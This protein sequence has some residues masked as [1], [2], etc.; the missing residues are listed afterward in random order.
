MII[1]LIIDRLG[2]SHFRKYGGYNFD[3]ARKQK[4]SFRINRKDRFEEFQKTLV[5]KKN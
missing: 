2:E 5:F 3:S 4:N 1:F